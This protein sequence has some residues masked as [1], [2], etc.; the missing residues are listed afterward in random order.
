MFTG[1]APKSSMDATDLQ[2]LFLSAGSI[3]KGWCSSST[4]DP[5]PKTV[6]HLIVAGLYMLQKAICRQ[7]HF[8][9][10]SPETQNSNPKALSKM[11][12]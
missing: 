9:V 6:K 12:V 3:P 5:R 11:Q 10:D 2:T 7:G 1:N 8:M 4:K